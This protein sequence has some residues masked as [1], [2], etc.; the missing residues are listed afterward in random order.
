MGRN[1]GN[2][3]NQS[4]PIG[5]EWF[6]KWNAAKMEDRKTTLRQRGLPRS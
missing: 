2:A 4:V 3:T 5:A 6:Q 1:W